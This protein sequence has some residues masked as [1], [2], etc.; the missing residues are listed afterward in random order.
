MRVLLVAHRYPPDSFAGVEIY[1]H[2][3][4]AELMRAG[5]TVSVVAR[6]W[7]RT[8]L[9]PKPVREKQPDGSTLYRFDGGLVEIE[10]FLDHHVRLEQ[11]FTAAIVESAPDVVHFNHLLG[12]SPRF[13]EIAHRL[14]A[15]IVV[16]LHDF[17]YS[18]PLGHLQKNSGELCD[19]P[20]GGRECART[21]FA[22]QPDNPTLRWGLRTLYYRQLLRLAQRLVAGSFYV[23]SYFDRY[24]PE[25]P[26]V[27]VIPNGV[28]SEE[29]QAMKPIHASPLER[30]SLNIVF[31]GTVVPH[32]GPHIILDA[33]QR[34]EVGRVNLLVLGQVLPLEEVRIYIRKLREQAASIPGLE[35]RLYGTFRRDEIPFLLGDV[36]C[37]VVP[38]LVP[39]AGPQVPR[40]ALARATGGRFTD[41]CLDGNHQR[42]RNRV[43]LRG[44]EL[45]RAGGNTSAI[46]KGRR[47]ASTAS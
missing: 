26:P 15:A 36:D 1:T 44:R 24:V 35:L 29:V 18:C 32:K 31:W 40:E 14:R 9:T 10:R 21:C 7:G 30:G 45:S 6:R 27:Q 2:R 28:P 11:L 22:T 34:A 33:I 20:N 8:P 42:R 23:A 39:E 41:R 16:S 19:G 13:I 3:L 4:A 47:I 17:Y 37:V 5:D 12:L 25:L 46:R 43:Q 38:S